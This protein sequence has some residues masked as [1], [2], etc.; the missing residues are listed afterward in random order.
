MVGVRRAS[1]GG[2]RSWPLIDETRSWGVD[3]PLVL[4]D[5]GYGDATAFRLGLGLG[6]EE[7]KLTYAVG[8]PSRLTADPA[9]ARPL[10]LPYQDTGRP[11]VA[12]YPDKPMTVKGLVI[13]AGRQ[14]ARPVS[15]REGSQ[16]G[17]G[18]SGFKH[19]YSCFVALR[20]RPAGRMIRQATKAR[21]FPSGGCWP[22]GPSP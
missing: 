19:M 6:L 11:P 5:A 12:T 10:T 8:I 18:R 7:R 15:W 14:A 13:Q 1:T 22:N 17:K 3:V 9:H 2:G 21:N 20:I 16:P 4:A